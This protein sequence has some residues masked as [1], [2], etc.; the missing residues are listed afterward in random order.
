MQA[1]RRVSMPLAN[2]RGHCARC[3]GLIVGRHPQAVYCSPCK[4]E[5]NRERCRIWHKVNREKIRYKMR[6]YQREY[7]RRKRAA[8][9]G[10]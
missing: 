6:K 10:D 7:M 2:S 9:H 8:K 4:L 1:L 5:R 3:D